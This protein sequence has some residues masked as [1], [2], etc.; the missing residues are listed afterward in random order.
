MSA[1]VCGSAAALAAEMLL[2][3]CTPLSVRMLRTPALQA[4][5]A[6]GGQD[7]AS[8]C[9]HCGRWVWLYDIRLQVTVSGASLQAR[10]CSR[11]KNVS[12][13]RPCVTNIAEA[14][15]VRRCLRAPGIDRA[16]EQLRRAAHH[17]C[18]RRHNGDVAQQQ[19]LGGRLRQR[20]A[21]GHHGTCG[22]SH[23]EEA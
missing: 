20:V 4:H 12:C 17:Q 21:A 18:E 15:S 16:H 5:P 19:Q 7:S 22:S 23:L 13:Q 3:R 2:D 11:V 6:D 1:I 9:H 14:V 8:T 10:A